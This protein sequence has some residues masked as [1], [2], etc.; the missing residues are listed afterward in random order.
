MK[1]DRSFVQR[2]S[3]ASLVEKYRMIGESEAFLDCMEKV[4]QAARVNR[5]V[6]IIGERGTGKELVA[7]RL[8]YLSPRWQQPRITINCA[9]FSQDLLESEIFGYERGAFTGAV[10]TKPGRFELAAQGTLFLDELANS[11]M[12]LQEKLLRVIEYGEF[13][14]VG[15]TETVQVDSRI[16]AATNQDL[17]ALCR[18][19]RFK[20]DLLDRLSF[21]VITLPPL[22]ARQDDLPLLIAHFASKMAL[23]LDFE[24]TPAFTE[25]ALE[26]MLNHTWPGNIREL[27]N[28]V[29]RAVYRSMGET[30]HQIELDPFESPFRLQIK[31]GEPEPSPA[32]EKAPKAAGAPGPIP[33]KKP[34]D[35]P[36]A[37]EAVEREMVTNALQM[38]QFNQRKASETL[39]ISYYQLRRIM[40][41]LDLP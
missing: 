8:H 25:A 20:E 13:E 31:N 17:P 30:I 21:E 14:R 33:E 40:K 39:G 16:I 24:R 9:A 12:A 27:K 5:P 34:A 29:E 22:R 2:R 19:K 18:Q 37:I 38:H 3:Q 15:G 23:E 28:V 11:P 36:S 6:L 35:L 7:A 10:R 4:S 32:A 1:S 26:T 41:R